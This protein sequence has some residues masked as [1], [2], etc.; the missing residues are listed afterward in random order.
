MSQD[1]H[2]RPTSRWLLV[3]LIFGFAL[4]AAGSVS[5]IRIALRSGSVA[6]EV[7]RRF[8]AL[9]D[10]TRIESLLAEIEAGVRGFLILGEGGQLERMSQARDSLPTAVARLRGS[11]P[12]DAPISRDVED[13]KALLDRRV[14]IAAR[15]VELGRFQPDAGVA[16]L[17]TSGAVEL[18]D[19]IRSRLR[20][21]ILTQRQGVGATEGELYQSLRRLLG[22]GAG[23]TLIGLTLLALLSWAAV[24]ERRRAAWAEAELR[25]TLRYLDATPDAVFVVEPEHLRITHVNEGAVRHTGY[26]REELLAM[27]PL[28]L[29]Q[30]PE[31]Q[32]RALLAVSAAG[33]SP[34]AEGVT[35]RKDGL[36]VP[37]EVAFRYVPGDGFLPRFVVAVRDISER[38]R[39]EAALRSATAAA[40]SANRAKS[41]FVTNMSHELRTP[42]NS[43]IGFSE[44]L[45]DQTVG[46]LNPSQ[47]RYVS[48]VL[49]S[50]RHLLD[51]INDIL[52]LAK[53]ESGRF[54]LQSETF[55]A[56]RTI[57]GAL[58]I[59]RALATKRGVTLS[60]DVPSDLPLL[61]ADSTK[62]KQVLYNLVSNAVKFTPAGGKVTV[63]ARVTGEQGPGQALRMSV[64]DTG[65]GIKPEDHA[66]VWREFE[67]V[68]STHARQHPGTGLGLTLTK[69]I[70]ELHG[71]R[72]WLESEGVEGRGSTFTFEMPLAPAPAA[73][74]TAAVEIDEVAANRP[75]VL[76]VDDDPATLEL[77]TEYLHSGGYSVA[78]ARTAK[79]ALEMAR[80]LSPF[81]ITLDIL[82]P[83]RSGWE[84]LRGL[85]EAPETQDIPVVVV[86][87][88]DDKELGASLGAVEFLQKPVRRE[89]LLS[90]LRRLA[91]Q[92]G[93]P[94]MSVLV[95][96][97]DPP[98]VAALTQALRAEG[99]Q[100]MTAESGAEGIEKALSQQPDVIVL[101]ILM[102]GMDGFE[103]AE[104]LH[105]DPRTEAIPILVYTAMSLSAQQVMQLGTKVRGISLKP[106]RDRLL[107]DLA[108]LRLHGPQALE[109]K[110]A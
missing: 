12:V 13:V 71:G 33:G 68:D 23:S 47:A 67:Q 87:I 24:R 38:H 34:T 15:V 22:L 42:L 69:R 89:Q 56:T 78:R 19:S 70:V 80:G 76:V 86:T 17:D 92:N 5:S 18:T 109:E 28:E 101:D 4:I 10:L 58:D 32:L 53:I 8:R 64:S 106:A 14:D 44:M 1:S 102:P 72:I 63:G 27:T 57:T 108:R 11:F 55:D 83:D 35:R 54:R 41:Q 51:L 79:Q 6:K 26:V 16:F 9:D 20:N 39:A 65:I 96:D 36:D 93:R 29:S 103:V 98:S 40:E 7:I 99:V 30:L 66:R 107:A 94:V 104:R 77:L 2:R 81:G 61:R 48:N 25:T 88:T 100:V 49:A 59:V 60:S 37:V 52:D 43:I 95:V 31:Q 97:D 82:L 50:G 75:L 90:V 84:V 110:D 74:P 21:I 45:E 105:A 3:G 73:A 91:R 85:K 46:E 62:F